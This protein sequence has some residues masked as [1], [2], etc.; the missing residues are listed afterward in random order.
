MVSKARKEVIPGEL[1]DRPEDERARKEEKRRRSVHTSGPRYGKV[2]RGLTISASKMGGRSECRAVDV[3]QREESWRSRRK[4]WS[5]DGNGAGVHRHFVLYGLMEYLRKSFDRQFSSDE[6]LR[7][8][9]RFYNLEML[10]S[11]DD[12]MDILKHEEDFSLPQ[13]YFMKEES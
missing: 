12:D 8:L 2:H 4:L 5:R 7:L 1:E 6:V 13:S 3:C 9:D 11:D 10:K